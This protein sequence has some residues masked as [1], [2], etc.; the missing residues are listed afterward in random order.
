MIY[1]IALIIIGF[2][3]WRILSKRLYSPK[4]EHTV[5]TTGAPGTGKTN[6]TVVKLALVQWKK[7]NRA[8]RK[9][10]KRQR[11]IPILF[12]T[13]KKPVQLYSNLPIRIGRLNKNEYIKKYELLKNKHKDDGV[14]VVAWGINTFKECWNALL[15]EKL[16]GIK[17]IWV[18]RDKFCTHLK[19]EHLLNQEKLCEKA[20]TVVTELGK[21][22]DQYSWKNRNVQLH[23]NDF[24]SMYRQYT[25]G[26]Y[27][28]SDDQATE[29]VVAQIR[30]R[31]GT[32]IN[33][34][35]YS[36]I[37]NFYMTDVRYMHISEG[38]KT[39]EEGFVE[40]STKKIIGF[41]PLFKK[42][43]DTYAFS[44]RYESVPLGKDTTY[45]SYKTNEI[46]VVPTIT[47]TPKITIINA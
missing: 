44:G 18:S 13:Y 40:D 30:R 4:I 16:D 11:Y 35:H 38:I 39:I 5:L 28:F 12:R 15:D 27:F 25:K 19:I 17:T 1:I 37:L 46:L 10:N 33:C 21:V 34:V 2:I 3:I 8:V 42:K 43:Y 36:S 9:H 23:L 6:L 41:H 24:I 32:V 29:D 7:E 31:I 26:G 22:A 45:I 14:V 20:V 47:F